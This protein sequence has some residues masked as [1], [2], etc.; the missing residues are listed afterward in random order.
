VDLFALAIKYN[1][2]LFQRFYWLMHT[3]E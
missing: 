1:N 2:R 3:Y